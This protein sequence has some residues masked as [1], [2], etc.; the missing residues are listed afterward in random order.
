M[1]WETQRRG[2]AGQDGVGWK[3]ITLVLNMLSVR[4]L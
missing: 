4:H 2:R 1:G 3:R